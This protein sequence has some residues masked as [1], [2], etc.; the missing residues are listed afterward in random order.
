MLFFLAGVPSWNAPY[1]NASCNT[2][3]G[4]LLEDCSEWGRSGLLRVAVDAFFWCVV[5]TWQVGY[6]ANEVPL[7]VF[8]IG[9]VQ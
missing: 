2:P 7:L 9:A 5:A 4:S 6:G 3:D 1:Y 8:A